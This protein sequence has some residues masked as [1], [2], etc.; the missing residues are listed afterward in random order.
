MPKYLTTYVTRGYNLQTHID[1]FKWTPVFVFDH[2]FQ[3][4]ATGAAVVLIAWITNS[5]TIGYEFLQIPD[6]IFIHGI[7]MRLCITN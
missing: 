1:H 2:V 7:G 5:G 3:Q 4:L 6:V